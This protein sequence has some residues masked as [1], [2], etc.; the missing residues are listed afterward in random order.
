[1]KDLLSYRGR[2]SSTMER[3]YVPVAQWI[4][5][6]PAEEEVGG[7]TPLG[8]ACEKGTDLKVS[9]LFIV[10]YAL[11]FSYAPEVPSLNS[12]VL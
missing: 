7:S 10:H 3:H 2:K 8:Y 12:P 9:S 6:F 1:M 5:R 4:E 11:V